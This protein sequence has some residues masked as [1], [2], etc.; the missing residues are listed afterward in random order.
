MATIDHSQSI[1]DKEDDYGYWAFVSLS[2]STT[3]A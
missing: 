3:V 2:E 1:N